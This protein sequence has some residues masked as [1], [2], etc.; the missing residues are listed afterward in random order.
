MKPRYLIDADVFI[1]A[2]NRYYAFDIC[3]GFW[4]SLIHHGDRELI[5]SIDKVRNELLAGNKTEDLVQWVTNDLAASFFLDTNIKHVIDIYSEIM[6]WVEYHPRYYDS[7]KAKFATEA[8]GWLV[9]YASGSNAIVVTNE[10]PH[11][12][13]K[14]RIPLPEVCNQF[15]VEYRDTFSMLRRLEVQLTWSEKV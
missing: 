8:D 10:R 12:E 3:P 11:P 9:A 13:S 7:A 14:S 2:K 6:Q 15:N 1:A 4:K 5:S